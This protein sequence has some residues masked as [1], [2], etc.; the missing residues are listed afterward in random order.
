ML[1]NIENVK[2][3]ALHGG[4]GGGGGLQGGTEWPA[5]LA[6]SWTAAARPLP[7]PTRVGARPR[8]SRTLDASSLVRTIPGAREPSP[9]GPAGPAGRVGSVAEW[10]SGHT[11]KGQGQGP[12]ACGRHKTCTYTSEQI[13]YIFIHQNVCTCI[14]HVYTCP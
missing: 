2:K 11:Q 13:T 12:S 14:Y 7:V 1:N 6:D 4:Q 3:R 8:G 10:R 5:R 9:R